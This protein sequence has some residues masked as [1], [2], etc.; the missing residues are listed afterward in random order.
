MRPLL[1][2][3]LAGRSSRKTVHLGRATDQHGE[4]A[5]C[6]LLVLL[7]G[8]RAWPVLTGEASSKEAVLVAAKGADLDAVSFG[9]RS[10]RGE[11]KQRFAHR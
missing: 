7:V 6:S 1:R 5:R 8:A 4:V 9:E 10:V 3:G 11:F 2:S